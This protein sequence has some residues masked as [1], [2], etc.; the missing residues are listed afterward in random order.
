MR[1]WKRSSSM[2]KD[3]AQMRRL[4]WPLLVACGVIVAGMLPWFRESVS[5]E[6]PRQPKVH[7]PVAAGHSPRQVPASEFA[8]ETRSIVEQFSK[9]QPGGEI[10]MEFPDSQAIR[11][12]T[13]TVNM[14]EVSARIASQPS[15]RLR[16]L[17]VI[18][19]APLPVPDYPLP[20]GARVSRSDLPLQPPSS[21]GGPSSAEQTSSH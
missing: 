3:Q 4:R 15:S 14:R 16:E 12:P 21:P 17:S 8:G 5:V 13:H 18:D 9:S 10:V 2:N 11:R 20:P 6:P 7:G 19:S 1:D